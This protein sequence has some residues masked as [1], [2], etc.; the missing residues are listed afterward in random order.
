MPNWVVNKVLVGSYSDNKVSIM[1]LERFRRKFLVRDK[2]SFSFEKI[3]PPPDTE[4]YK[5]KGWYEW[6]RRYWGTKWDA[7]DVELIGEEEGYIEFTFQT[8]WSAPFPVFERLRYLYPRLSIEVIF[9]DEDWGTNCGT[10]TLK[11]GGVIDEEYPEGDEAYEFARK[12]WEVDE[13]W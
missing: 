4:Y 10:L 9:A 13:V 8:P 3:I 6:N 2:F 12:V 11:G 5:E 1:D 7:S